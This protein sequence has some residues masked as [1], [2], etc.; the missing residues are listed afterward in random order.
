MA[1]N[2]NSGNVEKFKPEYCDLARNYCLLG[3]RD[4]DLAK[5]FGCCETTINNWKKT[6]P[7]FVKALREGKEVADARVAEALFHRA[8]GYEHYEDHI[9]VVS[10]GQGLGSHV[11]KTPT[12]KHYPPDATSMIFWLK[13]RQP[14]KWKDKKEVDAKVETTQGIDYEKISKEDREKISEILE[15]NEQ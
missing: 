7:E 6:H 11:E 5:F 8:C 3:A 12:V 2:K 9:S 13:N 10:D 4:S 1:G 15:R 14:D